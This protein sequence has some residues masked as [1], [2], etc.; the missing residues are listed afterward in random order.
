MTGKGIGDAIVLSGFID[1]LKQS[2]KS[3]YIILEK[4]LVYLFKENLITNDGF[5]EFNH[6]D[7]TDNF[8][9][10]LN[11]YQFD[12]IIDFY[13]LDLY[14][15]QRAKIISMCKCP[16]IGFNQP[17]RTVYTE[18]IPYNKEKHISDRML[19]V[20]EKLKIDNTNFN[21]KINVSQTMQVQ[22]DDFINEH[23]Q[24]KQIIIFNPFASC[25]RRT[26]SS[27]QIYAV[28][29]YLNK[30]EDYIII[31]FDVN[32]ELDLDKYSNIICNPFKS[33]E[34]SCE[35]VRRSQLVVTVDTSIVHLANAMNVKQIA[36]YNNRILNQKFRNNIVWA[37]NH[38][39]ATQLFTDRHLNT[40]SGDFVSTLD[41]NI[42]L[43]EIAKNLI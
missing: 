6:K 1:K 42:L 30:F 25:E 23:L 10:A 33:F 16:S 11:A 19:L 35:L 8:K 12:L 15:F 14:S 43:N 5:I 4:R 29:D 22:I 27:N 28:L 2:N 9:N 13:D 21:Y 24:N 36:I 17:K 39:E 41:V 7:K 18:S 26:M 3:V 20:L 38:P 37:P 32:H 31:V 34:S 40:F